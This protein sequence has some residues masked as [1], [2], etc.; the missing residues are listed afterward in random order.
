M[1][2]DQTRENM[3]V[4]Q[5]EIHYLE[6]RR[7]GC[8]DDT[9]EAESLDRILN[10]KWRLL[11]EQRSLL[12]RAECNAAREAAEARWHHHEAADTLDLY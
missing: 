7:D 11:S 1:N 2:I 10:V 8:E 5:D 9:P 3:R 12:D 4:L 6:A